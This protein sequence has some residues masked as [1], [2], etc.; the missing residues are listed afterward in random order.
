MSRQQSQ[1]LFETP[2]LLETNYLSNSYTIPNGYS[3]PE[4]EIPSEPPPYSPSLTRLNFA[5]AVANSDWRQAFLNLNGLNMFEMVRAL[6]VLSAS[7]RFKLINQRQSF[8]GLVNTPR[9]NYAL[10]VVQDNLLPSVVPGDLQSTG[11]VATAQDFLIERQLRQNAV[12]VANSERDRWGNGAITERDSRIV[13]TLQDYWRFGVN[14]QFSEQQ[15]R[16]PAFQNSHP[17][18]A[19]FISWVFRKAGAGKRFHYAPAHASYIVWAKQNRLADNQEF[20]KAYR[21]HEVKPQVGDLVCFSRG[22]TRATYDNIRPGMQTHC[23][24]VTAV[25]PGVLRIGG[26]V[27][28]SVKE[29]SVTTNTDGYINMTGCFAV[30][31]LSAPW[32]KAPVQP[33]PPPPTPPNQLSRLVYENKVIENQPAFISKVRDISAALGIKPDWLMALMNHESGLNHRIQ[34]QTGGATGLIQFMPATAKRLGIT[35]DALRSMSNVAQ[36]DYVYKYFLPF[37]GRIR[38]YSDLYLITFYPYALGKPDDYVFGSE[39]NVAWVKKIR[40]Q[41]KSIDLN[42]D[43]VITMGEFKQWIYRGI[44]NNIRGRLM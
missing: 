44:P 2:P 38:S 10:T 35:I 9:I 37:R 15:L 24:L 13:P 32:G 18:S 14:A 12:R 11:Q 7:Q 43:G 26:N 25:T 39:K 16:N 29:R 5:R 34:N 30:I 8:A 19:A 3:H 4:L 1:W 33:A 27:D 36:L 6:D 17:W 21:V 42:N 40:D 31:R 28:N 23:D 41:N 22:K 20:F